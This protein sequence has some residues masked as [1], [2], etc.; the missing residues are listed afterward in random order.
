M[1]SPLKTKVRPL[2]DNTNNNDNTKTTKKDN[3]LWINTV[4][5]AGIVLLALT[6]FDPIYMDPWII[7]FAIYISISIASWAIFYASYNG[8]KWLTKK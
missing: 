7:S 2:V 1:S 8:F 4:I 3:S 6:Y 5:M